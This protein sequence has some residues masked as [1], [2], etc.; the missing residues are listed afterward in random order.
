MADIVIRGME[1]PKDRPVC[2]YIWPDGR[3]FPAGL[4]K[5]NEWDGVKAVPLPE[6]HG[7]LGDLDE[8][9][10]RIALWIR[11]YKRSFT[12]DQLVWLTAILRG[13][14]ESPT[15]VPAEGGLSNDS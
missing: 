8:L 2:V 3:V 6:G 12:D 15:I 13:I 9:H 7:R 1:M 10:E 14:E 4:Y 5:S 11:R